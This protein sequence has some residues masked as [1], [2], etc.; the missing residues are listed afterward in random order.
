MVYNGGHAERPDT[1]NRTDTSERLGT[2][3]EG[4]SAGNGGVGAGAGRGQGASG[5]GGRTV[6]AQL[7]QFLAAAIPR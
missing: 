1:A 7:A 6:A 2:N 4:R 5:E 3:T